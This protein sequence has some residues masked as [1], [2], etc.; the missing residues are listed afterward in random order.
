MKYDDTGLNAIESYETLLLQ[1]ERLRRGKR[2]VQMF[3]TG[4]Q[5]LPLLIG[6]ERIKNARGVFHYNPRMIDKETLLELSKNRR[7]NVFLELG[8]YSKQD[9]LDKVEPSITVMEIT[10][11]GVEVRAALCC[12]SLLE[13]QCNYFEKTKDTENTIV[14]VKF[15]D[16]VMKKMNEGVISWR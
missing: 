2:S 13:D 10:K 12:A 3:P 1:Q 14:C 4:T 11:D 5:E 8:P 16:R 6:F 7:E 15:A 9:V